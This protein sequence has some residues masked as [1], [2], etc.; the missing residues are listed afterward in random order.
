MPDLVLSAEQ[1]AG[2]HRDHPSLPLLS[3]SGLQG[4]AD[5]GMQHDLWCGRTLPRESVRWPSKGACTGL[6][7]GSNV[8]LRACLF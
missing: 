5:W 7:S 6:N 3:L 8:H 1:A 2:N 4:V